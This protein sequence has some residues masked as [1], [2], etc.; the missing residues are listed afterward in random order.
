MHAF[1]AT[2]NL[3]CDSHPC[4]SVDIFF[5]QTALDAAREAVRMIQEA[6]EVNDPAARYTFHDGDETRARFLVPGALGAVTY[7]AGSLSAYRFV[8]GVLKLALE[9]GLNLQTNTPATSIVPASS[10]G[11][12]QY[13]WLVTPRGS[14]KARKL[15]LATNG[16]SARL[17]PPLQGVI[18]PLRGQVTVQRAGDAMP[19]DGLA[20]TYSFIHPSGY[21]YMISRPPDA[22]DAGDIVIGG[23]LKRAKQQGLYE[24][25][26]C[27]DTTLNPVISEYLGDCLPRFFG[28]NWGNDSK[29]GRVRDEW[30][31]IMGYSAD[32]LPLVGELPGQRGI[33]ISASFQGSGE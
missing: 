2:H 33:F 32:G 17:W 12:T 30:T 19:Q 9:K 31:G 1:A 25:G 11:Q 16:Y 21:D 29:T 28:P 18:V 7:E 5:D 14:I 8:T 4:D 23:G 24:Y 26:D 20:T 10:D 13:P 27:D 6:M 22:D 3:Q 15:V